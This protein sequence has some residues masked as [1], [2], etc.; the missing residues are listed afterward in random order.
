MLF[1]NVFSSAVLRRLAGLLLLPLLALGCGGGGDYSVNEGQLAD[2][3]LPPTRVVPNHP[4][5]LGAL[6]ITE[7]DG[8]IKY[9]LEGDYASLFEKW[10]SSFQTVGTGRSPL[11]TL[12][13]ATF[14]S[15]E[16]S[17]A[18]LQPETGVLTI[19]KERAQE[20]IEKR[21]KE[22]FDVIQIDVY[23]FVRGQQGDGLVTGPGYRTELQ[24]QDSTYRP[25][26]E[27]H[28]PLRSAFLD[29][30][31]NALYR[32]NTLF[33][34]RVVNEKDILKN[35][36][37]MRLELREIGAPIEAQFT[38]SWEETQAVRRKRTESGTATKAARR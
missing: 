13:Y 23:W 11:R 36:S 34:P 35:A 9:Q 29:G 17:L 15:L 7:E 2:R 5:S 21:R 30:A 14:W 38:W 26:R 3:Y 31:E 27:E 6:T 24:V 28:G 33:F 4:D 1:S 10:S 18:S 12:S 20:L 19:R 8:K 16:L 25:I 32:R 22:Y 37:K